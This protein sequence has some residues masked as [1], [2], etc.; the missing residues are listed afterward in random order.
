MCSARYKDWSMQI[1]EPT[2]IH[3]TFQSVHPTVQASILHFKCLFYSPSNYPQHQM[4]IL[5][6]NNPSCIS[7]VHPTFEVS[8]LHS[9]YPFSISSIHATFKGPILQFKCPFYILSFHPTFH[10][11]IL[12][13]KCP[14][15]IPSVHP[16]CQNCSWIPRFHPSLMMSI[17]FVGR[18]RCFRTTTGFPLTSQSQS[19]SCTLYCCFS[20]SQAGLLTG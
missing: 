12:Q 4:S 6:S 7:S 14:S 13:S 5:H 8:I 15:H 9:K 11:S 3:P 18:P 2:V 20:A 10:V 16:T 19:F 17:P 1:L